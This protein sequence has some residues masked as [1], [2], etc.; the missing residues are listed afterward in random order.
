MTETIKKLTAIE[1]ELRSLKDSNKD[2]W[3]GILFGYAI[4]D[5]QELIKR[6]YAIRKEQIAIAVHEDRLTV[7]GNQRPR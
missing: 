5:V 3:A 6:Q 2:S 4:C 1:S 7:A